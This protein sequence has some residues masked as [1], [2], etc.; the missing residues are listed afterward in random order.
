ML[1]PSAKKH[2]SEQEGPEIRVRTRNNLRRGV[3]LTPCS[4]VL[5]GNL[6]LFCER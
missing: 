2:T 4:H 6:K 1:L 5:P 3:E